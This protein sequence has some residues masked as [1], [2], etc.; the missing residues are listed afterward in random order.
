VILASADNFTW[1]SFNLSQQAN[2][3]HPA[4]MGGMLLK[5]FHKMKGV[6]GDNMTKTMCVLIDMFGKWQDNTE[7]GSYKE[8]IDVLTSMERKDVVIKLRKC[9]QEEGKIYV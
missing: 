1:L 9:M 4:C 7:D 3:G 5:D 8:L 6:C 2:K